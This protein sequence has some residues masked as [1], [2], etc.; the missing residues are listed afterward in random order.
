MEVNS[1]LGKKK[2]LDYS[3]IGQKFGKLTVLDFSVGKQ[4]RQCCVC[5]CDC[6]NITKVVMNALLTGHKKSCGS[7][8]ESAYDKYKHLIG[9][10]INSWTVLNLD[11]NTS[12]SVICQCQCGTLKKISIHNLLKGLSKDCGCGRKQKLSEQKSSNLIGLRFGKLTV[13]EK[14][15]ESNKFK[16]ILYR[17]QC[18]CGSET[19]VPSS[20]LVNGSVCSCGCLV[21]KYNAQIQKILIDHNISFIP[22]YPIL[23]E[24]HKLRFDFYLK[25]YNLVIEYDGEQ[26]YYPINFGHWDETTLNERFVQIQ[27]YDQLK[28][29]YCKEHKINLLRIPYW[30]N[31]N[32]EQIIYN[33]L[34]RLSEKDHS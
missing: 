11:F 24:G 2:P 8:K 18:D 14:L 6:G 21:S 25:D 16:R 1:Y 3:L 19:I 28:N 33:H 10:Q 13:I 23:I 7:C 5:Q 26:H 20:S 34:Q 22:E 32:I 29:N 31:N 12:Y 17:C 4:N 27:R 30:E 15:S 9:Q